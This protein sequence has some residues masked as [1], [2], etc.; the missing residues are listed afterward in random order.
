MKTFILLFLM[1]IAISGFLNAQISASDYLKKAPPIPQ[2]DCIVPANIQDAFVGKVNQLM[3]MMEADARERKEAA[4][5]FME[6]H[7][8]D[9]QQNMMK[10]A[11]FD[12]AAIKK[13]QKGEKMSEAEAMEMA[14]KM[15][16][17]QANMSLD[18][19]KNLKNMSKE[20]QEAWAQGYAAE[21]MAVAQANPGQIKGA[22]Q[23]NMK[24]YEMLTEQSELRNKTSSMENNIKLKY[25]L[26]EADA[27]TAKVI[28]EKE[29]EPLY[30]ELRSI[31][32][33]E[34]AT[35]ADVKHSERVMKQIHDKQD[36]F[37]EKFTPRML[38]F[39]EECKKEVE[40]ALPDY[41]KAEELQ[42]Q[43]TALQTSTDFNIPGKGSYSIAAAQI[44]LAY[45]AEAYR[46]KL[47]RSE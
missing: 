31:N 11:G 47:Y 17:Q 15:I 14:N 12:D 44:Y 22:D 32:D 20:G 25:N 23:E 35:E 26:L 16:Q 9:M 19:A 7:Q 30:K 46:Y 24:L 40:A 8:G 1:S 36:K 45:L 39:L 13:A 28:L 42:F 29:L 10:K 38:L 34:G 27:N 33:G 5:D 37:C 2:K 21:Q 3:A 41:D 4:N 18:E 6:A 43:I